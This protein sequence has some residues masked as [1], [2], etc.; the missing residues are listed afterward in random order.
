MVAGASCDGDSHPGTVF[1]THHLKD[2]FLL[3][4]N[5]YGPVAH[6]PADT[7]LADPFAFENQRFSLYFLVGVKIMHFI[8]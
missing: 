8:T 1:L 4:L 3:V 5:S 2:F 7:Q 6:A